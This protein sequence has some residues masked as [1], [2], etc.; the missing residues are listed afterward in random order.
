MID[1]YLNPHEYSSTIVPFDHLFRY[2]KMI[3]LITI[4]D[5]IRYYSDET[6]QVIFFVILMNDAN[7][8]I[9]DLKDTIR[10]IEE[11]EYVNGLEETYVYS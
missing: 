11:T 6:Q 2:G 5:I 10:F 3:E 9:T 1:S 8:D 4:D 7:F